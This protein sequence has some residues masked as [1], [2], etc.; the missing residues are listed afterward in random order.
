LIVVPVL[1]RSRNTGGFLPAAARE[2]ASRGMASRESPRKSDTYP[3]SAGAGRR[4]AERR[5]QA[6]DSGRVRARS[7]LH[8]HAGR[9][10]RSIS[11]NLPSTGPD[12]MKAIMNRMP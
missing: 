3:A 4:R 6:V 8:R 7:L 1:G 12:A 10:D 2:R 9:G 5:R 11:P